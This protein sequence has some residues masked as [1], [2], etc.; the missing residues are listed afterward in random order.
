MG[1]ILILGL[2]SFGLTLARDLVERGNEVAA[3]DSSEDRVRAVRDVVDKAMIADVTQRETLEQIGVQSFDT[4]VV[5]LGDRIDSSVLTALHLK[6]LG[7]RNV[8]VKGISEDHATVL[9]MVG[10]DQVVFPERDVALRL[11]YVLSNPSV[12]DHVLLA[13]G[14]SLVELPA[15]KAFVGKT[16]E[17]LDLRNRYGVQ[18]IIA[19]RGAPEHVFFPTREFLIQEGDVLILM[20]SDGD[21]RRVQDL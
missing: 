8:V 17:D 11:S 3:V 5:N 16:L 6:Q 4:V 18:V 7:V 12:V 15:S 9:R 20:A 10:A 1:S 13:P 2:G 19:K 14:Y 21:L